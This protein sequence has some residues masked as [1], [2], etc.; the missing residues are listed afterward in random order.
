MTD[1][2]S[3]ERFTS[4][5]ENYV[6]YRPGY[7]PGIIPLLQEHTGLTTDWSIAD[8]GAGPGNLARLFLDKGYAVVGVEP[9]DAMREAG[10]ALLAGYARFSSVNGTAESTTLPGSSIDLITAGQ[11]F[12]WFDPQRTRIEFERILRAPGWVALIWN[13]RPEGAAPILDAWS[14]ML[15]QL[16]PDYERVRH[17][18]DK[19]DE[20]MSMLFGE[21]GVGKFT[22]QH[23]QELDA[24]AF[25]GRLISSSYTPLPGQPGHEEV[26]TRSQ[27]IFDEHA[28]GGRVQFP[29]ETQVYIGQLQPYSH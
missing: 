6:R 1:Q 19:A 26:K 12:H 27:Q 8:V 22:L 7:P 21:N 9:N 4:R 28:I 13:K 24:E 3:T 29:Y 10:E 2:R 23:H 5:V 16:S 20:G 18:D 25:W 15:L 11:A 14:V 17:R